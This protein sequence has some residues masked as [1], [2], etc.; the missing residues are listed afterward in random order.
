MTQR[1]SP[2]AQTPL[3][4]AVIGCGAIAEQGHLP[5]AAALPD[6]AVT[7]LVDKDTA[8][9]A[10]LAA[11]FNMATTLAEPSN[12]KAHADATI[13]ALPPALH[14]PVTIDLLKQGLHVLVEKPMARTT[15]ECDAM[16]AAAKESGATLAVGLVRRFR[17]GYRAIKTMLEHG[18][19]GRIES[20]DVSEG[21]VFDWPIASPFFLDRS[22]AGGGVLADAGVHVL[23]ALLWWFGDAKQ[24]SY[25]DDDMGGVEADCE[26]DLTFGDGANAHIEL[27]RTRSMRNSTLIRGERGSV[28]VGA[29]ANTFSFTLSDGAKA[30]SPGWSLGGALTRPDAAAENIF[31]DQLADFAAAIREGRSPAVSGEEGRRSVALVQQC[32]AQRQSLQHPW[33][34][35]GV[36]QDETS[37]R[38]AGVI[39]K[40]TVAGGAA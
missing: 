15:G 33:V 28:E 31:A 17:W 24:V 21:G 6:V 4:V 9:A 10:K 30:N 8:R 39:S 27:S 26:L 7:A 22:A 36:A 16:L 38:A 14:A 25:R 11:K 23:D 19:L 37:D 12:L 34:F 3:R 13:I 29:Y 20:I 32:Y 1:P 2:S 5:G 40:Q 18:M 35:E